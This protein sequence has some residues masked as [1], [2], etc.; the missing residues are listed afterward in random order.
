MFIT[1]INN[2]IYHI[3]KQSMFIHYIDQQ[4]CLFITLINNQYL[5]ITLIN[6]QYLW[7]YLRKLSLSTQEMK[8]NLLLIIKRTLL[9]YLNIP[10]T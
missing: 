4:Q 2:N 1:L 7:L 9:H 10:S 3:D 5:F 6:N 8:S